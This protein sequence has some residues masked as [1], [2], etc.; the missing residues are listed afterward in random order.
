MAII[1]VCQWIHQ[2]I[3][4]VPSLSLQ[5]HKD[6][7][8][9]IGRLAG[10]RLLGSKL[11]ITGKLSWELLHISSVQSYP[12]SAIGQLF[13]LQWANRAMHYSFKL[14]N[15]LILMWNNLSEF[16]DKTSAFGMLHCKG[17][18]HISNS[19]DYLFKLNYI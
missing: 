17:W 18:L 15:I 4:I 10:R 5:E 11:R 12:S 14:L 3:Y 13:T 8:F 9:R 1:E 2:C 7:S 6:F 16:T 19:R